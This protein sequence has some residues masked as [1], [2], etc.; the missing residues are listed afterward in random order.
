M[1]RDHRN[2]QPCGLGWRRFAHHLGVKNRNQAGWSWLV[3][4]K[5]TWVGFP[6]QLTY[7]GYIP[8]NSYNILENF[9]TY[10]LDEHNHKLSTELSEVRGIHASGWDHLL[11]RMSHHFEPIPHWFKMTRCVRH[12]VE[13]VIPTMSGMGSRHQNLSL[14][15][16]ADGWWF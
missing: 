4:R 16:P 11:E 8:L 5:V 15:P 12:D 1:L 3:S 13:M 7:N 14:T 10:F 6:K 9:S 2:H